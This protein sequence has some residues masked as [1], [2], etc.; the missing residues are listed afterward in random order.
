MMTRKDYVKVADILAGYKDG[1]ADNFWWEDL[2]NDFA[3]MFAEDNPNFQ[4]DKFMEACNE[5]TN[6]N[7][8]STIFSWQRFCFISH[9]VANAKRRLARNQKRF[10]KV[11]CDPE[12]DS[13]LLK[14]FPALK[15]IHRVCK[16]LCLRSKKNFHSLRRVDLTDNLDILV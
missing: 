16:T 6:H 2:L 5:Q 4:H 1:M 3:L 12:Q 15:V 7:N 9:D 10:A 13:K 14:N 8:R 11:N